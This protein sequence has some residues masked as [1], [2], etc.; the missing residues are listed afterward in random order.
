MPSVTISS[1][2]LAGLLLMLVPA[3]SAAPRPQAREDVPMRLLQ[4]AKPAFP[5]DPN[6]IAKCSWWWDN[7][8][9][10]PCANM[11]AEWGITMQ[12]F[13]RWNPSITS[14]CGNF[15][16]GRSYCVEAS[17]E[18]PPVPGTPTTTTAPATTT[19]PSNGITTPQPIQDG[20]VG[21]CN[22]F[23]YISEGDRCQDILSYQKI[24]LADFFKWNPAVKSD[25]SGLWSK[26]N[27]CVGVV[28]QAP[29]VTTTTTKPATPTTPS[30]GIT[31]P[32]PIQAG[33]V[34]NCNKFHYISEG[35]RC[36]DILSYQKITQADFFKWN[37][38]VK[39]DCSGLWSKTHAC[40]GVIGGQAPPPTPT[41]TKPTTTKPPG[42]GVT[43][44]TP[45]QP[46]MVTNC[47]KFHFV[48]PGNT[49]QQIV[50]YQ[51]I[52]MANFVKWNSGAGSGCN[53]LWGNTHA[54][55][56]VF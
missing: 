37:P 28:G 54:C 35:D 5:Y 3:S 38:A 49:C 4:D 47:N 15:L 18:E 8:G 50:S 52:T 17:G 19:K 41:T 29:A 40:V 16:N 26:T 34:G 48:S 43:T 9:Q 13:L 12:D 36:Q 6:T 39:S 24:T 55:V 21:N 33:M 7:E 25:C 45:T 32:Q 30:N 44:P 14:S 53:N 11:P 22:K 31:T 1:T 23:H 27:A 51:K 56:G 2:M 46:G 10:I 42:N 20:M